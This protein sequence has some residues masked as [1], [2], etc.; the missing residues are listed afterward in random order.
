MNI[1]LYCS[2][3]TTDYLCTCRERITRLTRYFDNILLVWVIDVLGGWQEEEAVRRED[4]RSP[5]AHSCALAVV[6]GAVLR[7]QARRCVFV[8]A[9]VRAL[10]MYGR[11]FALHQLV[12]TKGLKSCAASRS[13]TGSVL[14]IRSLET[15][16]RA[17]GRC[18]IQ[19]KAKFWKA[20][21]YVSN[22]PLSFLVTIWDRKF[23]LTR[24]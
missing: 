3:P 9:I 1:M 4:R 22:D 13:L 20:C 5:H 15:D 7:Q 2:W 10:L 11:A 14:A 18:L 21:K 8:L 16:G 23:R 17:H 19:H 6:K 24:P 12:I